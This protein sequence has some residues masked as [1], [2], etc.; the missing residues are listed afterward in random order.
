MGDNCSAVADRRNALDRAGC[1]KLVCDQRS[2]AVVKTGM[3]DRKSRDRHF[4]TGCSNSL[5]DGIVIGEVI[6]KRP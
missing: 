6:G 3:A 2:Q 5:A 1:A 4:V